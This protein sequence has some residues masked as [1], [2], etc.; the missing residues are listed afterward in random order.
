MNVLICNWTKIED[1][2]ADL[3][4]EWMHLQ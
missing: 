2:G 1:L 3:V 4:C